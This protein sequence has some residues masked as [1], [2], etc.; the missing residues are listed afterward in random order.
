VSE[1]IF[2]TAGDQSTDTPLAVIAGRSAG[3]FTSTLEVALL[4]EAI[5][6]AVHSAKDVPTILPPGLRLAAYL[7][8]ADVRDALISRTGATLHTL[9]HQAVIGTGSPRRAAQ[10]HSVRP[11]L[12]MRDVRGN[13]DTRLAKAFDPAGPYDAI[14]LAWA[15]LERL[16][17]TEVISE[18][19]PLELMLPAPAQGA[20]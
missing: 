11:D 7:P 12:Q 18:I 14:V 13:L 10:L 17:R 16:G 9:P 8:R 1:Q 5:D 19:L 20:I 4:N 2:Q 15:G 3:V 6:V